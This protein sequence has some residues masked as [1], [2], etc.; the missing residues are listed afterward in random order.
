[1][2]DNELRLEPVPSAARQARDFVRCKLSA[3]GVADASIEIAVLLTSE[4]AANAI[5]HERTPSGAPCDLD[6]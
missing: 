3:A 2:G 5:E 1:M 4:L 6:R